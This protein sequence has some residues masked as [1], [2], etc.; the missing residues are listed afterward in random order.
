M[1]LFTSLRR[2]VYFIIID[3]ER[4]I[5]DPAHLPEDSQHA[6]DLILSLQVLE[7]IATSLH[8]SLQEKVNYVVLSLNKEDYGLD[9]NYVA[10]MFHLFS[11]F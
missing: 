2:G 9:L 10:H 8:P 3:L 1:L 4:S 6:Q 7:V 11:L 5:P